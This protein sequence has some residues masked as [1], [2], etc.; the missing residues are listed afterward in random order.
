MRVEFLPPYSPDYNPIELAFNTIKAE[1]KRNGEELRH[2]LQV[3]DGS[4]G[5]VITFLWDVVYSITPEHAAA[6][7][8]K[9]GYHIPS[10]YN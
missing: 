1:I 7:F 9:C 8:H 2:A 10:L 6:F 3:D 4:Q 5:E